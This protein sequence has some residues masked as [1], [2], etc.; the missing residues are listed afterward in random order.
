MPGIE[1][2]SVECKVNT[3]PTVLLLRFHLHI[4]NSPFLLIFVLSLNTKTLSHGVFLL[5]QVQLENEMKEQE[6]KNNRLSE[7]NMLGIYYACG[8]FFPLK[9]IQ[10]DPW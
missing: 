5:N 8:L 10:Q 7:N 9:K 2:G 3:L 1:S 6:R 4:N